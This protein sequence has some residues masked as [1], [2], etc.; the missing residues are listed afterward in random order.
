MLDNEDL[1][2]IIAEL[3]E[4]IE[5][6][7]SLNTFIGTEVR[8]NKDLNK[9]LGDMI[10]IIGVKKR[11]EIYDLACVTRQNWSKIM[12]KKTEE[13]PNNPGK[14]KKKDPAN[15]FKTT[16]VAIG[17]AI[18]QINKNKENPLG[19]S[20]REIMDTLLKSAGNALHISDFDLVII[21]CLK[22]K[23]YDVI[24]VNRLLLSL[25]N[26]NIP[27]LPNNSWRIKMQQRVSEQ[28]AKSKQTVK[29]DRVLLKELDKFIEENRGK[30]P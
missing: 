19:K 22:K 5:K 8:A 9:V 17:F 12:G 28:P 26:K 11:S 21:Y 24:E 1:D 10:K 13:D 27:V 16:L 15:H 3:D 2:S 4:Y 25:K 20:P 30:V 23:I 6:N 18:I 14:K 7:E 29:V